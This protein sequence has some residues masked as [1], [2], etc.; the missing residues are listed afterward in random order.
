MDPA[1]LL[2]GDSDLAIIARLLGREEI[3]YEVVQNVADDGFLLIAMTHG[4]VIIGMASVLIIHSLSQDY[5]RLTDLAVDEQYRGKGV[6]QAL[7]DQMKTHVDPRAYQFVEAVVSVTQSAAN[8]LL[9]HHGFQLMSQ[10]S[11][12][13]GDQGMSYYRLTP[14]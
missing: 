6:G 5:L 7:L 12:E 14:I 1:D 9:R 10:A 3:E 13:H 4:Q 8:R 11:P 2:L